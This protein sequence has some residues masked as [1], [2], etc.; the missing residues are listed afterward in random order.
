MNFTDE[1]TAGGTLP[2]A[3]GEKQAGPETGC[4]APAE[5]P[6]GCCKSLP[7]YSVIFNRPV[8]AVAVLGKNRALVCLVRHGV[9]DWNQT[10]R[11]QGRVEVPLNA[12]GRRQ[13]E[14][15]AKT[16]KSAVAMGL[17]QVKIY[18]S[19]LSR[20]FDTA[21]YIS[22]AIGVDDIT[23]LSR[24]NERDYAGLTGL[25][26]AERKVQFPR[27]EREVKNLERV[28]ESGIRMK[29]A[30]AE[31]RKQSGIKTSVAVT[32][33]GV[34]NAL[35]YYLTNGRIGTGRNIS[36]N[37]GIGLVAVGEHDVIPLA[38]NLYGDEFTAYI[39]KLCHMWNRN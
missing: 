24:L 34:I 27:G 13:A 25:T 20:A 38:Y 31:I 17:G 16:I 33:G 6:C 18:S 26:F 5:N 23:V 11:L 7:N 1:K 10:M 12:E 4:G 21:G 35:Y 3:S 30:I 19:P 28:P 2:N 36:K 22:R 37:C 32:H 29:R 15:V 14:E 9:T 8:E 39:E